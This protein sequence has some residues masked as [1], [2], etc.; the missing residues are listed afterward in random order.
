VIAALL[1]SWL[2]LCPVP[3]LHEINV[4]LFQLLNC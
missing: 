2:L 4:R 1:L 3:A